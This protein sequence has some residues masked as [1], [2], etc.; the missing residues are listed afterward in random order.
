M[1]VV[2]MLEHY[3][4]RPDTLDRIR[5]SGIGDLIE[6]YVTRLAEQRYALR[7]VYPRV[8]L[9]VHF[10][11]FVQPQGA[12][13]WEE[14]AAYVEAFVA[15]RVEAWA[16]AH[17]EVRPAARRKVETY[18]RGVLTQL[19]TLGVPGWDSGPRRPRRP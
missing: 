14:L 15:H 18:T 5:S 13:G 2:T 6:R 8:P 11:A 19:L 7:N 9:L 17:V 3:F 10:G 4:L 1:E 12:T 16:A